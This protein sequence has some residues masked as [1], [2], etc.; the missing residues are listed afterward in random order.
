MKNY[1]FILLLFI[2]FGCNTEQLENEKKSIPEL[3]KD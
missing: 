1:I 3:C 2:A